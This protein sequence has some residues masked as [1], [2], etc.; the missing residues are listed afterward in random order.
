MHPM[1]TSCSGTS[2]YEWP[3]DYAAYGVIG[4]LARIMRQHGDISPIALLQIP[5]HVPNSTSSFYGTRLCGLPLVQVFDLRFLGLHVRQRRL[6][7]Q[8]LVELILRLKSSP[9]QICANAH[10]AIWIL[11]EART[12][13]NRRTTVT[14]G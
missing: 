12:V 8:G 4:M 6:L 7:Y 5:T 1:P 11:R 3:V 10:T 2:A 14:M 9:Q 13:P